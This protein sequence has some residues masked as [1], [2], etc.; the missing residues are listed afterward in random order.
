MQEMTGPSIT[1]YNYGPERRHSDDLKIYD[2]F[3]MGH[4]LLVYLLLLLTGYCFAGPVRD[5]AAVAATSADDVCRVKNDTFVKGEVVP[6]VAPCETCVCEPPDVKCAAVKCG[7]NNG[8]KIIQQSG[9]CCPEYKCDCEYEGKLYNNGE[10]L[11]NPSTPCQVCYCR[12]GE[13]MCNSITCYRR[14]DCEPQHVEG[15]CCPKYGHCPS[16]NLSSVEADPADPTA[17]STKREMQPWLL[18]KSVNLQ[19]TSES[20]K[21][22][23]TINIVEILPTQAP[24]R[25][26]EVSLVPRIITNGGPDKSTSSLE[27]VTESYS[28]KS[29]S[30]AS[31]QLNAS[32]QPPVTEDESVQPG[33]EMYTTLLPHMVDVTTTYEELS[34]LVNP[35]T[36]GTGYDLET[37]GTFFPQSSKDEDSKEETDDSSEEHNTTASQTEP[38]T[39][40][41]KNQTELLRAQVAENQT[42]AH[43]ELE[44]VGKEEEDGEFTQASSSTVDS[45]ESSEE[46]SKFE[47]VV[48]RHGLTIPPILNLNHQLHHLTLG[49]TGDDSEDKSVV[50]IG[51]YD[52]TKPSEKSNLV[53]VIQNEEGSSYGDV[54]P[55]ESATTQI[56]LTPQDLKTL[57]EMII[58]EK[59]SAPNEKLVEQVSG[60]TP[61]PTEAYE[62][63]SVP[64]PVDSTT[65]DTPKS[66][67]ATVEETTPSSESKS[68]GFKPHNLTKEEEK[69]QAVID[70]LTS[71]ILLPLQGIEVVESNETTTTDL[72]VEEVSPVGSSIPTSNKDAE[73]VEVA[74]STQAEKRGR[75]V[76]DATSSEREEGTTAATEA[77]AVTIS[78]SRNEED[79]G[80]PTTES[81]STPESVTVG[82]TVKPRG[83][84]R[85]MDATKDPGDRRTRVTAEQDASKHASI[86][87]LDENDRMLVENF[88]KKAL[89]FQ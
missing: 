21:Y 13:I 46:T 67:S 49:G 62:E 2:S 17:L 85:Q 29:P 56:L 39:N 25:G 83:S 47:G 76:E 61:M 72:P 18:T 82:E 86:A 75:V 59:I 58:K 24:G 66:S 89:D 32:E 40:S 88:F 84:L 20:P 70:R 33:S 77:E 63:T 45:A 60:T 35:A 57:A 42:A 38:T 54:T 79:F 11:E 71:N 1:G 23:Q 43:L 73:W 16:K 3:Q 74:N 10:K 44:N 14:D 55:A 26:G 12:G 50:R 28:E 78:S 7:V 48:T 19:T 31:A 22:P 65:N 36:E 34:A 15:Q 53:T 30:S 81:S 9:K 69:A 52:P 8:C 37:G 64:S 4:Q 51:V 6:D 41:D 27:P 68:I 80:E 5:E 87:S